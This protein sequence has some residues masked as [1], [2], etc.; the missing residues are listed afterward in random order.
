ML[1][2]ALVI[3]TEVGE[4]PLYDQMTG[5]QKTNYSVR[6]SVLDLESHEKYECQVSEGIPALEDLKL[7]KKQGQP[8]DVMQQAALALQGQLPAAM[9]QM[10]L[11]VKRVK[12]NKGGFVTLV[13]SIAAA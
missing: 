1:M 5:V 6:M 10:T 3:S 13:C 9:S 4:F 8:A 7:L 2:Q 12:A 11:F